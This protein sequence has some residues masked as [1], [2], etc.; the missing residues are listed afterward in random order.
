MVGEYQ[1]LV[2]AVVQGAQR[3]LPVVAVGVA[4]LQRPQPGGVEVQPECWLAT[5]EGVEC[6]SIVGAGVVALLLVLEVEAGEQSKLRSA[7]VALS[8]EEAG[9]S[10]AEGAVWVQPQT[11]DF[12]GPT[13]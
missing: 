3:N 5:R 2:V 11:R 9:A 1:P 13:T 12:L 10:A 8:L 7:A 6:L 4:E